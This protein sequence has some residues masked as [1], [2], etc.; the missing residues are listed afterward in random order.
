VISKLD[1]KPWVERSF[2]L[3]HHAEIHYRRETDY[4][5]RL[6]IISFDNSIEV[7]ITTY[8]TL[9]PVQRGN[10]AYE[11]KEVEKWLHNFHTKVDFWL[12]DEL[13]GLPV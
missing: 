7:S 9:H 11:K 8:L 3:I 10:R 1:L 6:A 4:D 2:E 13:N 12:F 5:R